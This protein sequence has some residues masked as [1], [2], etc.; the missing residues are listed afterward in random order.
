MLK[1]IKAVWIAMLISVA[2]TTHANSVSWEIVNLSFDDGATA[3]GR[4]TLDTTTKLITDFD[5]S[6]TTGNTLTTAF[7]YTPSTA[8]ITGQNNAPGSGWPSDFLQ[9]DSL[10]GA[11]PGATRE[12]FLAF[13][14]PLVLGGTATILFDGTLGRTSYEK[15]LGGEGSGPQR[16]VIGPGVVDPPIVPEPAQALWLVAAITAWGLST[17]YRRRSRGAPASRAFGVTERQQPASR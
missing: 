4:F 14:G 9:L 5:I 13:S 7:E 15:Q 8:R 2:P 3:S 11:I 17:I 16:L 12:L 10:A 1:P 6:T